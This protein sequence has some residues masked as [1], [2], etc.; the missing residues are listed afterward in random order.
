VLLQEDGGPLRRLGLVAPR[1]GQVR[2]FDLAADELRALLLA[3][4]FES[5]GEDEPGVV[6]GGVV[7]DA[8][9]ERDAFRHGQPPG[10]GWG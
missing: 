4:L 3:V 1:L 5:V 10:P 2:G 6:V 8:G 9:D 7:E